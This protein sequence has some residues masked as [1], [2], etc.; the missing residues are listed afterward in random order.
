MGSERG[1]LWHLSQYRYQRRARRALR[2]HYD[3]VGTQALGYVSQCGQDRWLVEQLLPPDFTEG[4]FVDVGAHDGI[5]FSNTLYLE[6]RL[7]WT[8][9]AVEP[10]PEVFERL[11]ANRKCMAV[12]GCVAARRGR[13]SFQ[14][15]SGYSEMLSGLV[16]TYDSRHQERI[17][18]ELEVRGGSR[19]TIT[20]DCFPLSDLLEQARI[21]HV[22]YLNVDTEGAEL[23]VLKSLDFD[24][25]SVSIIGVENNYGD[26][27]VPEFLRKKGYG[28]HSIVGDEFY[29]RKP[30]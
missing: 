10:I 3:P 19:R 14:V 2:A 17:A 9:I 26:P 4:V 13:A 5:S 20:V 30:R 16:E 8:G 15:L 28:L 18:L 12:N 1:V 25:V 24:E 6:Q 27:G 22:D 21:R 23:R 7:G 29:L 11:R